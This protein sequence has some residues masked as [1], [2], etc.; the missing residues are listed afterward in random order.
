LEQPNTLTSSPVIEAF[1][2]PELIYTLG[3]AILK[4]RNVTSNLAIA[5]GK[6]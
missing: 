2:N 5:K 4:R 3:Q 1:V 6:V